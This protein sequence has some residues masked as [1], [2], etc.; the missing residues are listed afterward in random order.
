M[1]P[2]RVT[3]TENPLLAAFSGLRRRLRP[4]LSRWLG[5]DEADDA[6]QEAF[7][8][9]WPERE[10]WADADE[11]ARVL[12][13]TARHIGIDELR[14]RQKLGETS[15]EEGC[16]P[17]DE[18][19]AEDEAA[20]RYRRVKQIIDQR[21]TPLQREILERRE[22]REEAFEEIAA[23]LNMQP[24]AVRMQLSRARKL[25]REVYYEQSGIR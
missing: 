14:R 23:I 18:A 21:L 10:R 3:T 1:K 16:D 6:L 17:T 24:A 4:T 13:V 15:L 12:N 20:E 11:A 19:D 5:E 2:S 25:I 9:L 8:R 22:T 7:C